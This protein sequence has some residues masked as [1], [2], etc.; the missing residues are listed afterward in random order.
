MSLVRKPAPD[1]TADA[2]YQYDFTKIKLSDYK[3]K[4]VLLFF[5]PLDFTFVCPT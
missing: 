5:Y 2:W 3:G 1:F 4:Y